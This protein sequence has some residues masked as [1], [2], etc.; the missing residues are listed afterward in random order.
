MSLNQGVT[1][2]SSS[3]TLSSYNTSTVVVFPCLSDCSSPGDA[4]GGPAMEDTPYFRWVKVVMASLVTM[5]IL[6]SNTV[7]MMALYRMRE[8]GPRMKVKASTPLR[9]FQL[10]VSLSLPLTHTHSL[11]LSL[12]T[13]RHI[14]LS[15]PLFHFLLSMCLTSPPSPPLFL[16]H[17]LCRHLPVLSFFRL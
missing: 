5:V 2:N 6:A 1:Q 11:R 15:S 17:C 9:L 14:S 7:N 12:S 8:I 16:C 10:S 3:V 13:S 4:Q